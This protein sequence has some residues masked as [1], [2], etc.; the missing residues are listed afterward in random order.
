MKK[1]SPDP[2]FWQHT[3]VVCL[4]NLLSEGK[5]K[6]ANTQHKTVFLGLESSP[7]L[8]IKFDFKPFEGVV[9]EANPEFCIIQTTNDSY[10][11]LDSAIIEGLPEVGSRIE[12]TPYARRYFQGDRLD[13][14][15][16]VLRNGKEVMRQQVFSPSGCSPLPLK[17]PKTDEGRHI[18]DYIE[19]AVC[20]DGVR[21][22]SN[23]LVD[24]DAR[25]LHFIEPSVDGV[26]G[27]S[28]FILTFDCSS[29]K[30]SGRV[31]VRMDKA[32]EKFGLDLCK[33]EKGHEVLM[34]R[35]HSIE[36]D[37]LSRVMTDM[38]CDGRWAFASIRE[39]RPV[40]TT[41]SA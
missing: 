31:H 22:L 29:K 5:E 24:I 9:L 25:N 38:L 2:L 28:D 13:S 39:V 32:M 8:G 26:S 27:D 23:F 7:S 41:V 15:F 37:D 21:V 14:V 33:I 16:P 1:N 12:V 3:A 36:S 20:P 11:F 10:V 34:H 40:Q 35:V 18:V 30:F 17:Q 4:R 6:G 19:R